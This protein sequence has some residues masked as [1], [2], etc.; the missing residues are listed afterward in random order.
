MLLTGCHGERL[1]EEPLR[2]GGIDRQQGRDRRS[3]VVEDGGVAGTVLLGGAVL[4]GEND[5]CNQQYDSDGRRAPAGENE[6]ATA[7]SVSRGVCGRRCRPSAAGG[8][9]RLRDTLA[10]QSKPSRAPARLLRTARCGPRAHSTSSALAS[11][12]SPPT[13]SS[14]TSTALTNVAGSVP[15]RVWATS[16]DTTSSA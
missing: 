4:H 5:C 8:R 1:I 6:P 15:V 2:F 11:F 3:G 14:R 12:Q 16:A 7:S 13:F 10:R 9:P